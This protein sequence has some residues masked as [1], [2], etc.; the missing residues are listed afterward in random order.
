MCEIIDDWSHEVHPQHRVVHAAVTDLDGV[1]IDHH[2]EHSR[3]HQQT[4]VIIIIRQGRQIF[5]YIVRCSSLAEKK[6]RL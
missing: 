6:L 3:R 4:A 1:A 2:K 5:L